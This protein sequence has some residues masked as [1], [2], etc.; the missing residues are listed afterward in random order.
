M[1]EGG[2]GPT[3]EGWLRQSH[4][5]PECLG[6]I[7][8]LADTLG[9]LHAQGSLHKALRPSNVRLLSDGTI[10]LT[11]DSDS[12]PSAVS[13]QAPEVLQGQPYTQK[14]E[15]YAAG[16]IFY[17]ALSGQNPFRRGSVD[18]TS[19]AVL[20]VQPTHLSEARREIARDLAD[21]IMGCLEK[22]PDWRPKDLSY[23]Q[24]LVHA[25]APARKVK[26]AARQAPAPAREAPSL[27]SLSGGG[28]RPMPA[29]APSRAPIFLGVAV[30]L[31]AAGGGAWYMGLFGGA[32]PTPPTTMAAAPTTVAATMPEAPPSAAPATTLAV[33]P[34]PSPRVASATP[35][36]SVAT[37][38]APARVEPPP[39]LPPATTLAP[40]VEAPPE[41][42]LPARPSAPPTT[43]APVAT[44]PAVPLEPAALKNVV[45]PS[46]RRH[47]P[48]MI[49]VHGAGLRADHKAIVF[50][51]KDVAAGFSVVRQRLVG[52]TLLQ[53]LLTVDDSVA[54][55]A[56]QLAVSDAEGKVTNTVR[57]E[58]A[59]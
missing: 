52:P 36:P 57:L 50:R 43:T 32:R 53:V 1:T 51:G 18:G 46:I 2:N 49:D 47:T 23:I 30:V 40:H 7:E 12:S 28:R 17:E 22:D 8:Q 41:T 25:A 33:R 19:N 10:G 20:T 29:P 48:S 38:L 42:T 58:V 14:S 44:V 15:I 56:Y 34:S 59:K 24:E 21:A 11:R 37:T 4:P 26:A 5:L 45:P 13:Y 39:T 54:P 3:L 16:L 35:E 55:G 6:V 31:A 27:A 9:A